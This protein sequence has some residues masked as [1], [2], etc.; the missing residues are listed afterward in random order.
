MEYLEKWRAG[1]RVRAGEVIAPTF[2][3]EFFHCTTCAVYDRHLWEELQQTSNRVPPESSGIWKET[4]T[5]CKARTIWAEV[6]DPDEN[7]N[8][9]RPI[10][11]QR[12]AGVAPPH[13]DMPPDVAEDYAEAAAIATTS[14]RGSGALLRLALQ[15]L[16]PH[17]GESSGNLNADISSLVRKGLDIRV[18]QALD[19]LRVIGN[20]AV[21]PLEIDLR[22]NPETVFALFG[23][24]NFIVEQMVTQPR[25]LDEFYARL[26]EGALD[27]IQ[28]RDDVPGAQS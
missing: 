19:G 6:W 12:A 23:L 8:T 26:P 20:N 22:E 25:K 24:L 5:N 11:P 21:H 13:P 27:A 3:S 18:Q 4:C 10:H 15:K 1:A 2:K 16:M 14:A 28:K 7:A 17:L 9:G